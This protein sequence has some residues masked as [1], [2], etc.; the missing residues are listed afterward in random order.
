MKRPLLIGERIMYVNR[1]TPVN[2]VF[3]VKIQGSFSQA[4]LEQALYIVQQKHPMLRAVVRHNWRGRPSFVTSQHP[5]PI[6]VVVKQ[7]EHEAQWLEE[8][9]LQWHE[10]FGTKKEPLAR[11][12]WLQSPGTSNLLLVTAHC[13]C[14]GTSM[15]TLLRELLQLLDDPMHAIGSYRAFTHVRQLVAGSWKSSVKKRAKTRLLAGMAWCTLRLKTYREPP[16][17][18]VEI[19]HYKLSRQQTQTLLAHCKQASCSVHAALS[20]AFLSAFKTVKG[21]AAKGKLICPADIRQFVPQIKADQLFAYAPVIPLFLPQTTTGFWEQAQQMKT[22]LT[23]ILEH[24]NVAEQLFFGEYFH[25]SV[26]DMIR[27]L[28]AVDGDHDVTLSNMGK[29]DIPSVYRHFE[30]EDIYS[31]G[32]AFPWHNANTLIASTYRDRLD[33]NF[34]FNNSFLT[35]ADARLL[36]DTALQL[37]APGAANAADGQKDRL[38]A[39]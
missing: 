2:C 20:A 13:I 26:P 6:P 16:A 36:C 3:A 22:Q 12:V 30:V 31:P 39:N 18:Q 32:V 34:V 15:V 29:I 24:L 1:Q 21:T 4:A 14:D 23:T 25:A 27:M 17:G 37:L 33:C 38:L 5:A 35:K 11:V 10:P 28:K 8:M 7:R 9:Q 19:L